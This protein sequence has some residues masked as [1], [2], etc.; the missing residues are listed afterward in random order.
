MYGQKYGRKWV[1][2]HREKQK[3][4]KEKPK[5]DDAGRLRGI[6]CI[7]SDDEEHKETLKNAR[8]KLERPMTPAIPCKRAPNSITKVFAD[9]IRED[10][11]DGIWL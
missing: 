6:Y 2:P 4:A 1:K 7:D 9:C 8:R 11:R 5:I 10:S 3:W